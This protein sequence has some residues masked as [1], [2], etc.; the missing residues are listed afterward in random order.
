MRVI[1]SGSI[2]GYLGSDI[3]KAA[4]RLS[5]YNGQLRA[6]SSS[7]G[8]WI[9]T[10]NRL[11]VIE[12]STTTPGL[13]RTV[14]VL[15]NAQRPEAIGKPA[16][17]LYATRFLDDRLYA[18]TFRNVDPL[19]VIDVSSGSDPKIAGSVELPG[20]SDYLHPLPGGLLL[21]FGKDACPVSVTGDGQFA[22]YQGL[23]LSLFDVSNAN[24]PRTVKQLTMGKRGSSSA[25]LQNHHAFSSLVQADGSTTIAIPAR[26]HDGT[27]SGGGIV[28]GGSADCNNTYYSWKESGLMRFKV[29]G[30]GASAQL[31]Q[32]T[33]LVTHSAQAASTMTYPD[34]GADGGR[35]IQFRSGTVYVGT[36]LFWRLDANGNA[37]GPF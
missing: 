32:M 5:E 34:P 31:S 12:P 26:I 20:F 6:V 36:G 7:A 3:D 9:G 19:Y 30:T 18:V 8:M 2:E 4:F 37:T 14:S 33:G 29:Q 28:G 11:T 27:P 17:Q 24:Q 10:K 25:L 15:P 21:G 1:A 35:S 16:E 22:W 23:S 13:L